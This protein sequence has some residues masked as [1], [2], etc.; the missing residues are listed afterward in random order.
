[1]TIVHIV[2]VKFKPEVGDDIKQAAL[3]DVV[4]LKNTIPQIK[5]ASAGENFTNRSQGFNWGNIKI[6]DHKKSGNA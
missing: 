2:I 3:D 6:S 1:M 4:A 5:K